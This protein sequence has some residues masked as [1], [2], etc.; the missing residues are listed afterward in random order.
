MT[1]SRFT[2]KGCY[3]R[4]HDYTIVVIED[5]MI[6]EY[7]SRKIL[8]SVYGDCGHYYKSRTW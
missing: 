4:Y 8:L 5:T 3:G 7:L 2:F 1:I 6:V